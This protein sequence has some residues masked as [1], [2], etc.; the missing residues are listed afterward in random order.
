MANGPPFDPRLYGPGSYRYRAD[1]FVGVGASER[2]G[3][4][5]ENTANGARPKD[6]KWLFESGYIRLGTAI[7][8]VGA[9]LK[10]TLDIG[11]FQADY[12]GTKAAIQ[13]LSAA[14][15]VYRQRTDALLAD[16]Q[17]RGW[18]RSDMLDWCR[19]VEKT[20]KTWQC[21]DPYELATYKAKVREFMLRRRS[22]NE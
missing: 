7:V 12:K 4:Y 16:V 9:L 2:A 3:G 21:V 5:R 13:D 1:D 11:A 18:D 15:K 10:F 6:G 22:R 19:E 14:F 20:N 8:I 17:P